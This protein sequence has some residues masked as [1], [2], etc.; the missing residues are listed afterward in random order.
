MIEI[1]A[2]GRSQHDAGAVI[3]GENQMALDG[4]GRQNHLFGANLPEPLA[5][6][7]GIGPRAM[8]G[9]TLGQR[10][11]VVGVIAE[12]G[13]ARQQG[14]IFHRCQFGNGFGHPFTGRPAANG[15]FAF[16]EQP[17][18]HR[19]AFICEDDP[20]AG[21]GRCLCR[22]QAACA[23]TDDQQVAMGIAVGI[24]VGIGLFRCLAEAGGFADEGFVQVLPGLF[25]PHEGLVVEAGGK[26]RREPIVD[27]AHVEGKRGIMVL[28]LRFHAV[29]DFLHGGA[30]I[31]LTAGIVAGNVHQ[32]AG[33]LRA[34]AQNAARAVVL[35]RA[36]CEVNAVC[37]HG[38]SERVAFH[39][40]ELPAIQREGDRFRRAQAALAG[41]A[42]GPGVDGETHFASPLPPTV[43]TG[44]LAGVPLA[45]GL[46]ASICVLVIFGFFSPAL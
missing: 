35:E 25:R 33:F 12:C 29:E 6:Q 2:G 45:G 4:A 46:T 40:V 27:S 24:M 9:H 13:R 44:S 7:I 28:R 8:V 26:E 21:F 19:S 16:G 34:S 38:G 22:H 41:N 11:H 36:A 37:Q 23:A 20:L 42:I 18:T 31:G 43:Q 32:R 5:R 3:V 14:D 17:A 15:C 30:H 1:H 10:H 39:R